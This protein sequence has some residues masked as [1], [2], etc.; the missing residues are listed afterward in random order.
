MNKLNEGIFEEIKYR[1]KKYGFKV[2][3]VKD[4]ILEFETKFVKFGKEVYNLE[5]NFRVEKIDKNTVRL[6]HKNK[7]GNK[8]EY[9][10]QGKYDGIFKNTDLSFM[11]NY[12]LNHSV[13]YNKDKKSLMNM[14]KG[15]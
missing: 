1:Q 6:Y 4:D 12:C 5:D 8:E 15:A 9:H 10:I 3:E 14:Y 7:Q 2:L 13:K 11:L